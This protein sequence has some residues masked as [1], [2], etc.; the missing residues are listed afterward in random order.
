MDRRILIVHLRSGTIFKVILPKDE[1]IMQT[2]I[3][4][5]WKKYWASCDK[6]PSTDDPDDR[7]LC[8]PHEYLVEFRKKVIDR[9]CTHGVQRSRYFAY[10]FLGG[11]GWGFPLSEI[12]AMDATNVY[13]E[14]PPNWNAIPTKPTLWNRICS[15]WSK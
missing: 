14:F 4:G 12:V 9:L 10:G 8:I 11:V 3:W 5:D 1:A 15:F 6:M 13:E 7:V 2:E